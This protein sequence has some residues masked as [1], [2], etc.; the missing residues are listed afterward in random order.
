M[1]APLHKLMLL[2]FAGFSF[3]SM[4]DAM[5]HAL[6]AYPTVLTAFLSAI[7]SLV[8]LSL[9]SSKLGGFSDTFRLP[10]LRLRIFRGA[11]L[12]VSNFLAFYAFSHL[13]L[14]K[15]YTLVFVS[16]LLAKILSVILMGERISPR[17]WV[18]SC[19]GFAGVMVV[20][21]PGWVPL[22]SG[23]IAALGLTCFFSLGYVLA[24]YIGEENQTPLSMA[25]F[26]Y[27]FLILGLAWPAFRAWG[28]L[29]V[30]PS[31]LLLTGLV[32]LTSAMGSICVALAYARG[33]SAYIAPV[34]YT[35]I[36]WGT[37]W[38]AVIYSEYPDLW[39]AAG[40]AIIITTG[41]MLIRSGR[42]TGAE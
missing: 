9:F 12:A 34:H 40:G 22:D 20:L 32:G 8:F 11:V 1:I 30:S 26:Q 31:L 5:I 36:L 2:A 13:E 24:R 23:S 17:S 42:K 29:Q 10:K 28:D 33:P 41:L 35:Q 39:T 16:P 27:G 38:G 37:F 21:R 14:T 4:S 25:L 3:W 15:A 19:I 18:L 7:S 6:K